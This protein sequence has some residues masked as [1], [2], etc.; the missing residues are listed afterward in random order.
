MAKGEEKS[1]ASRLCSSA[2]VALSTTRCLRQ[3]GMGRLVVASRKVRVASA[4]RVGFVQD[5]LNHVDHLPGIKACPKYTPVRRR[6]SRSELHH[7]EDG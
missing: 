2:P 5:D 3:P 1:G 6:G 4:Q 7:K